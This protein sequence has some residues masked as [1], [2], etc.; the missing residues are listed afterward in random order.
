[1]RAQMV[2]QTVN[3]I[4]P[5]NDLG[6]TLPHEHLIMDFSCAW[7]QDPQNKYSTK[8]QFNNSL[9]SRA[10]ENPQI[11]KSNLILDGRMEEEVQ[12]FTQS[13]G[14]S[15]V[16]LTSEGLFP[17][18][19]RLKEIASNC[20]V[21]I[22][23]GCGF[24]RHIAQDSDILNLKS[25]RITEYILNCFYKGIRGT[26]IR[27]GVIGEVGTT[28]PLHPFEY[29]S[30]IGSAQAQQ[31]L[32]AALYIHPDIY[33]YCH[34]EILD[35]VEGAGADLRKTVMCHV[36]QLL[37]TTWHAKIA[38]R[39]VYLGFDTF[40]SEFMYD[41][42]KEPRDLQRVD[43][44]VNLLDLGLVNQILLSHDMCYK[45]EWHRYGGYGYDHVLTNIVPI[46]KGRGVSDRE[47]VTMMID[48]PARLLSTSA[49][50]VKL[51][52]AKTH[53]LVEKP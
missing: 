34:L 48:N 46:L 52:T 1:M 26:S 40:G 25:D 30:L 10:K 12:Y 31:I 14:R 51:L 43:C 8:Q 7:V 21:N 13:G 41:G 27:A 5:I 28:F 50:E 24:Y 3:G 45:I 2:V 22:I 47:I 19:G 4:I 23:A 16:E 37:D 6:I 36:D 38:Q 9:V 29:E 39:G 15:I 42:I 33:K 35:I 53:H 18:P 44:L 20:N 11:I 17:N 32:G 49:S